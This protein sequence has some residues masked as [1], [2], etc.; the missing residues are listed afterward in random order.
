MFIKKVGTDWGQIFTG[1]FQMAKWIYTKF[2]GEENWLIS[3]TMAF[4]SWLFIWGLFI[5]LLHIPFQQGLV[6]R[7]L[8]LLGIG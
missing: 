3:V 1:D 5:R 4:F 8:N 6:E 2:Q 7:G